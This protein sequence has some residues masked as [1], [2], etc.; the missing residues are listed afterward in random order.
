M[1]SS[2]KNFIDLLSQDS[3]NHVEKPSH[4]SLPQQFPNNFPQSQFTQ[5]FSPHFLHN[6]YPFGS[7]GNYPPYGHSPPS[8]QATPHQGNWSQSNLYSLQG[9]HLQEH[10]AYIKLEEKDTSNFTGEK[11]RRHEAMLNQLSKELAEE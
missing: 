6:F 9:F 4:N 11:L 7:P 5:S 8:L 1:D 10:M 3:P 2:N